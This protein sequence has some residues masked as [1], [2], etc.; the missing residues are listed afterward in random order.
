MNTEFAPLDGSFYN[1]LEEGDE[2]RVTIEEMNN[3]E[4]DG[5][6]QTTLKRTLVCINILCAITHL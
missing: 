1:S 5:V 2:M 4:V 6:R 3:P